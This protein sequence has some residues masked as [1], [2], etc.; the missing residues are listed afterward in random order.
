MTKVNDSDLETRGR[1]TLRLPKKLHERLTI[2]AEQQGVSLN[3]LIISFVSESLGRLE[4]VKQ[5]E[6]RAND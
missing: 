3:T 1:I 2:A 5:L 4:G 6:A